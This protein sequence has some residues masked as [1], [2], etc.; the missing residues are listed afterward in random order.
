M[1]RKII[2][3]FPLQLLLVNLKRNHLLLLFWII[4]FGF[5]SKSIALKYGIPYL[6]LAPEYLDT[7]SFWSYF[8]MGFAIGGFV[9]TF[10]ISSYIINSKRFSFIAALR[11]PFIKFCIN[12]SLLPLIFIVYYISQVIIFHVENEH[13]PTP[14]IMLYVL[15][16]IIGYTIN[17]MLALTYF[18]STNRNIFKI[19]GIKPDTSEG[20]PI[21]TIFSNEEKIVDIL[22]S[23]NKWHV[24][25]YL[26]NP[27]KIRYA[28][29]ISHYD[30]AMLKSIISQNSLNASLFEIAI[31]ISLIVLGMF[32]EK[33]F[34]VIPAGSSIILFFTLVFILTSAFYTWL[35]GWTTIAFV[36]IFLLINFLSKNPTFS[37]DNMAYGLNYNTEKAIYS[38]YSLN[39]LRTNRK[40][41]DADKKNEIACLENWKQKNNTSKKPK[42]IFINTSGGGSRSSLWTFYMLQTAD[43]LTNG[44]LFKQ[45]HLI[46]G[47]SGGMIGAAYFRELYLQKTKLDSS[48]YSMIYRK[49]IAK[50]LLNP[51]AFSIAT[52]DFFIRLKKYKDGDYTYTKDRGYSFERQLLLNTDYVFNK[53]LTDYTLPEFESKIP[54]MIFSPTVINDGRRMLISSQPISYLSNNFPKTA[55]TNLPIIENFEFSELFKNQDANNLKFSSALRMSATF[56][57]I[58]PKVTLPTE[59]QI[60][61]M[62]AGMRDNYGALTSFKYIYTFKDWINENTSGVII[63]SLRDKQK[64]ALVKDNSLKSISETF[65]S[66]VGSLYDN[67]F[68]IQDY[69]L[70]DMLQYINNDLEKTINVINFEIDNPNNSISLSWHLTTKEKERVINSIYSDSN[71]ESLKR[72]K[73]LLD[74]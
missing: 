6:F 18:I 5:V 3:F 65:L 24:E 7:V 69:A 33:P 36:G 14:Q 49:N 71:Q 29:S 26:H 39:E 22:R 48:I 32:S 55:I 19:L 45:T 46:T 17:I 21:S 64:Q 37:Y 16:I 47:S 30:E 59:P 63:I 50:D 12:N 60:A 15:G 23:G 44:K 4:L 35:K 58:M 28:R 40:K 27:F 8:I 73:K 9:M 43:S 56:P 51:V 54:I 11:R 57:I 62:D 13:T 10:N 25:Y 70:D 61:V 41:I 67:L 52:N 2:F 20:K 68:S 1:I 38:N 31:F 53:R 66:P 74:N 34:F 72:L 42:L